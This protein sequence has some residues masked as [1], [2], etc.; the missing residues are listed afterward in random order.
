VSVSSPVPDAIVQV[1]LSAL[2]L[3]QDGAADSDRPQPRTPGSLL[4]TPSSTARAVLDEITDVPVKLS[5][6]R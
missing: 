3:H 1:P 6:G 5:G 4:Q 2:T